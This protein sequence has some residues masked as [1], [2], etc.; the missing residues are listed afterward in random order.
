LKPNSD[1]APLASIV[2]KENTMEVNGVSQLFHFRVE[3]TLIP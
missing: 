1:L 3:W 2:E